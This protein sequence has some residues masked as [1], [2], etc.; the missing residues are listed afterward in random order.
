MENNDT[1]FKI[2]RCSVSTETLILE[3]ESM[4]IA[5]TKENFLGKQ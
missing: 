4:L 2:W 1:F 3:K 5:A